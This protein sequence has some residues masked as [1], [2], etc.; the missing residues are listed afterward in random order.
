MWLDI[1]HTNEKRY[2]TWDQDQ[3]PNPSKLLDHMSSFGRKMV[4][5]V[6]P[7]IKRDSK[8]LLLFLF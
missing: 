3:F 7:H 5:I 8:Y 1:E 6:D 2:F 4:T